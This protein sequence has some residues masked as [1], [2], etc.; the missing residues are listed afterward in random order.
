MQLEIMEIIVFGNPALF[1]NSL[2]QSLLIEHSLLKV[3]CTQ[4]FISLLPISINIYQIRRYEW[5]SS[6]Y[7]TICLAGSF[8]NG[9]CGYFTVLHA[10][11]YFFLTIGRLWRN[12]AGEKWRFII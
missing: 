10:V 11:R 12:P 3:I 6:I 2:D 8:L 9:N 4:H 5:T 1:A 7:T